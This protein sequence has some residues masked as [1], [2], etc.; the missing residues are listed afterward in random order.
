MEHE[1]LP[2]SWVID[3][4]RAYLRASLLLEQ[5]ASDGD[6]ALY[7]PATMNSAL[8]SELY[9]KS[10]LVEAD[11]RFPRSEYDPEGHLRLAVGLSGNRH[12]LFELYRA[13]PVDLA[14]KLREI[15]GRLSPGFQLEKWIIL[16]S[17]LF[18][19]TRYPYE[20]SF[21]KAID[22]DVLKLAPHLDRVLSEFLNPVEGQTNQER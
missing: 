9:L 7:W 12:N 22:S 5:H 18:V 1:T 19:G 13:I 11:P 16:C 21:T 2:S 4:A 17:T 15:S 3:E 14:D 20:A 6:V 8:A 10:F